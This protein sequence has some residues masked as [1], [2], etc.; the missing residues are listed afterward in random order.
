MDVIISIT[1]LL[2]LCFIGV[3]VI[4]KSYKKV[5]YEE[6]SKIC[7]QALR[8]IVIGFFKRSDPPALVVRF[9]VFIG[10][11]E[12][13]NIIPQLIRKYFSPLEKFYE[14]V[15]LDGA[16][17][18]NSNQNIIFY[19]LNCVRLKLDITGN[20]LVDLIQSVAEACLRNHLQDYGYN[21]VP[22]KQ[23]IAVRPVN[24]M[25]IIYIACTSNGI[26]EINLLRKNI[27]DINSK[28]NGPS[29][30]PPLYTIW[31]DK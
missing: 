16:G 23:M 24:G 18:L 21:D 31:E 28:G 2:A 15:D 4:V 25:I 9:P 30:P 8:G 13:G 20:E 19:R 29:D 22:V 11:D 12:Y 26:P 7:A 10:A 3:V 14:I 27:N 6:A 17:Y 5:T 1:L